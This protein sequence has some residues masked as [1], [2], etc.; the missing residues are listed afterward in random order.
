MRGNCGGF[1]ILAYFFIFFGMSSIC[2]TGYQWKCRC[3]FEGIFLHQ[4]ISHGLYFVN[5]H[6]LVRWKISASI[7]WLV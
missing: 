1:L 6:L 4:R 3:N 2:W 7:H 5:G